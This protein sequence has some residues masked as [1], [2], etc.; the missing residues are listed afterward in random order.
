MEIEITHNKTEAELLSD[1]K[2]CLSCQHGVYTCDSSRE[3]L[4]LVKNKRR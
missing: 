4:E 3:Y 2:F 1:M